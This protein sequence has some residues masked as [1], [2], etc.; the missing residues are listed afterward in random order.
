MKLTHSHGSRSIFHVLVMG[1]GGGL[2]Q[3]IT[4]FS[5]P[6]ITR[7]YSPADYAAWALLMSLIVFIGAI[8]TLRYELAIVLPEKQED[9]ANVFVLAILCSLGFMIFAIPLFSCF[10]TTFLNVTSTQDLAP[11]IK[12]SPLLIGNLGIYAACSS[13]C[14]RTKRFSLLAGAGVVLSLFTAVAQITAGFVGSPSSSRLMLGTFLGQLSASVVLAFL[15]FAT[16][17]KEVFSAVT[18]KGML[19]VGKRYRS[20]PTYMTPYS[21]LSVLQERFLIF[22]MGSF[23]ANKEL[24]YY[25]FSSRMVNVPVGFFASAVRP[26]F[27]QK[28]ASTHPRDLEWV[29][30]RAIDFIIRVATPFWVFFLFFASDIY[31]VIFGNEWRDASAFGVILSIPAFVFLF[32]NWMDRFLDALGQQRLAFK[33]GAISSVLTVASVLFGFFVFKKVMPAVFCQV[34]VSL[35]FNLFWVYTVFKVA[36][37]SLSSLKSFLVYFIKAAATYAGALIML[38]WVFAPGLAAI[39]YWF[40]VFGY[41]LAKGRVVLEILLRRAHLMGDKV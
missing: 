5:T 16:E 12:W 10:G 23:G 18:W 8:A 24:G 40:C 6:I 14:I 13:W 29:L 32:S 35:I 20:Y 9:A 27:F 3:F 22:I 37:Y 39:L 38:K 41:F 34:I 25:A 11:W 26:V 4:I 21:I 1:A 28:A 36:A 30:L 31:A 2:A 17:K 33:M 7:I 19:E 15:I